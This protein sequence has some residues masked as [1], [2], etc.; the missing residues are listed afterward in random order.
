MM[1][2]CING[3]MGNMD[4]DEA[5]K[6]TRCLRPKVVI[7]NHYGMFADNTA[8]PFQFR[9]RLLSTGAEST[10]VILKIGEK[11]VYIRQEG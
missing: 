2:V 6:L 3:K 9:A 8:D 7:P 1:L 4:I 11:Y 10:C 5:V